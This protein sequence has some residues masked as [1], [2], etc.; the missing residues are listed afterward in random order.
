M[1]KPRI[2]ARMR[3][4]A[5]EKTDVLSKVPLVELAGQSRV[6]IE[7][8]LGVLAYSLD[9]IQIK[10]KYGKLSVKGSK[11]HLLQLSSEQLVINGQIDALLLMGR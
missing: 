8:H 11:L 6:L 4:T 1:E 7:N 10:V 5:E 9:E 3:A 2:F